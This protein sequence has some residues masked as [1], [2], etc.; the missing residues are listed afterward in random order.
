MVKTDYDSGFKAIKK[1]ILPSM[2]RRK[3][4]IDKE[5]GKYTHSLLNRCAP[6][7]MKS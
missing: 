4:D 6:D 7:W 5:L 1:Q 2:K 3:V